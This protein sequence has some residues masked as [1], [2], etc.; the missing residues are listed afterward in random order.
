[1]PPLFGVKR[2]VA[3]NPPSVEPRVE[4]FLAVL[5]G[6]SPFFLAPKH[7]LKGS[8][9]FAP[10]RR[11]AGRCWVFFHVRH[12]DG[13]RKRLTRSELIARLAAQVV[14]LA[15]S[16]S[17]ARGVRTGIRNMLRVEGYT[18]VAACDI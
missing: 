15:D 8:V 7:G 17:N 3:F 13:D 10:Q 14:R 16:S 4:R 5:D 6:A 18:R 12:A 1:M 9:G 2:A 11:K